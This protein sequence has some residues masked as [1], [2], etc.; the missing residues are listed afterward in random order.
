MLESYNIP[1]SVFRLVLKTADSKGYDI[2]VGAALCFYDETADIL[3]SPLC[4]EEIYIKRISEVIFNP[5]AGTY[6]LKM[7]NAESGKKIKRT[8]TI[9]K[10]ITTTILK[11]VEIAYDSNYIINLLVRENNKKSIFFNDKLVSVNK[12]K[13]Y[14]R[15][16]ETGKLIKFNKIINAIYYPE[17]NKLVLNTECG[18]KYK[19]NIMLDYTGNILK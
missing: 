4:S 19:V 9:R 5:V 14:I 1:I 16:K 13:K 3:N 12:D 15:F 2:N 10:R 7:D 17:T 8:I 6:L 18:G 11:D